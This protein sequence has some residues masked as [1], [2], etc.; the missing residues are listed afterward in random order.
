[1]LCRGT[2]QVSLAWWWIQDH[3]L[4]ALKVVLYHALHKQTHLPL[5]FR[6]L[7]HQVQT[8]LTE[9]DEDY[10]QNLRMWIQGVIHEHL[11]LLNLF[12]VLHRTALLLFLH[13]K[14]QV[15]CVTNFTMNSCLTFTNIVELYYIK[16]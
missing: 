1:M 6:P 12:L 14:S 5:R 13:M 7:I 8:D 10:H 16:N 9:M 15:N 3:R 2:S 4:E 11:H